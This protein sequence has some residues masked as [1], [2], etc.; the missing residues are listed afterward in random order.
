MIS[1][2]LIKK[3]TIHLISKFLSKNIFLINY[4]IDLFKKKS[5]A[6]NINFKNK[7]IFRFTSYRYKIK[8]PLVGTGIKPILFLNNKNLLN[9][10][11]KQFLFEAL[12]SRTI[13]K[14]I[15]EIV[16]FAKQVCRNFKNFFYEK[17]LEN[18]NNEPKIKLSIKQNLS[19]I[20]KFKILNH[21]QIN[22]LNRK[23]KNKLKENSNIL[24]IGY[25]NG[26]HSLLAFEKLGFNV[27]GIDNF[28]YDKFKPDIL[29]H[30]E[31]SKIIENNVDF[32]YGDIS[33][34]NHNIE[35][36]FDLI[37][38]NSVLEHIKDLK[39]AFFQMYNL[40][41]SNGIIFHNYNPFFSVNGGHSLGI[42]DAPFM[43]LRLNFDDYIEYIKLNRKY[44]SEIATSW[45]KHSMNNEISQQRLKKIIY[46]TGFEIIFFQSNNYNKFNFDINKQI[47]KECIKNYNFL[48][49][50]DLL[51]SNVTIVAKK[52]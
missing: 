50:D 38:S 23:I 16:Y 18:F 51:G 41:K 4:C 32:V 33:N 5:N 46:E 35:E 37:Y 22:F 29:E 34:S 14:P 27:T 3:I 6:E 13:G 9:K 40:L 43:H 24:E 36:K 44:E 19:I 26:G 25:E 11:E 47:F 15:E 39:S 45:L 7:I 10:S 49:L 42:G 1:K 28:Y 17:S 12:G 8:L 2:F 52:I 31:I 20:N 21:N 30:K 48:T